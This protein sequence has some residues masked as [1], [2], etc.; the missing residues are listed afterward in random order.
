[1]SAA[2]GAVRG[3]GLTE[4]DRVEVAVGRGEFDERW[5]MGSNWARG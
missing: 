3:A 5:K 2:I 1:M 4:V